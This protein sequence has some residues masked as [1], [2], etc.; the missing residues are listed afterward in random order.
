M[1]SH[2]AIVVALREEMDAL[3]AAV[4]ALAEPQRARVRVVQGGIGQAAAA[5]AA[6]YAA[7]APGLALLCS[8]GFS[9]GCAGAAT[10]GAVV[11]AEAICTLPPST[12]SYSSYK[13]KPPV[14][15]DEA[16]A[17][18]AREALQAAGLPFHS[19]PLVFASEPILKGADKLSVGLA[20]RALAVDMECGA[21]ENAA[22]EK[23]IPFL[24]LR[25]ISDGI[26]DD[27][28]EEIGE[29]LDQDGSV[30]LGKVTRF[31]IKNPKNVG[32]LMKLKENA[33][34]A[35]A[36]LTL[37]WKAVLPELLNDGS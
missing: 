9:G 34:K 37:A 21:V 27:L 30:R 2:I 26:N 4:Q 17:K 15:V 14:L 1:P 11:L 6:A 5:K 24:A 12:A 36:A 22:R 23:G 16:A 32:V 35:S 25:A 33:A 28:P 10:V 18:K 7:V 8:T 31:A 29:F 3:G 20:F 13:I 19:G